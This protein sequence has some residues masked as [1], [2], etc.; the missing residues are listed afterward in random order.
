MVG[1]GMR[2]KRFHFLGSLVWL[3]CLSWMVIL[4]LLV[5]GPLVVCRYLTGNG[6]LFGLVT[7]GSGLRDGCLSL[8]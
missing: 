8:F 6:P 3:S 2:S 4:P 1:R 7:L 5:R